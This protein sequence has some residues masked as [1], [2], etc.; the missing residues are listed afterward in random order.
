MDPKEEPPQEGQEGQEKSSNLGKLAKLGG[1]ALTMGMTAYH[2]A[3]K[4]TTDAKLIVASKT[5]EVVNENISEERREQISE[6]AH[7]IKVN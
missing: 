1:K 4:V 2:T 6:K 3:E 7:E 5:Q